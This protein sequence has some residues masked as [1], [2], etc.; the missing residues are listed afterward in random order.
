[1]RLHNKIIIAVTIILLLQFFCIIYFTIKQT[2]EV[3][4]DQLT[5]NANNA[6]YMLAI[7]I[8]DK[9]ERHQIKSINLMVRALYDSGEYSKIKVT[10][11]PDKVI[12][13][14]TMQ[15]IAVES[16]P[17]W[18]SHRLKF[19][20]PSSKAQ[21]MA[22]WTNIG[23]VEV[24]VSP[25]FTYLS[26]W[27]SLKKITISFLII[28]IISVLIIILL[29]KSILKPVR[30]S[31]NQ[32]SNLIL[33][34]YVMQQEIPSTVE[35]RD[36]VI[37]NNNIG[38]R[39]SF[40]F[41]R[42]A[43]VNH[44][45]RESLYLVPQTPITNGKYLEVRLNY[46]LSMHD[47]YILGSL[48]YLP[49]TPLNS[50]D[51]NA[52][53]QEFNIHK[54]SRF[55][56]FIAKYQQGILIVMP[57]DTLSRSQKLFNAIANKYP[58]VLGNKH[59]LF[60][61]INGYWNNETIDDIYR[62]IDS[63]IDSNNYQVSKMKLLHYKLNIETII[64]DAIKSNTIRVF[65]KPTSSTDDINLILFCT[66]CFE[67]NYDNKRLVSNNSFLRIAEKN[68][69]ALL[70]DE[71]M[72]SNIF[73]IIENKQRTNKL[74]YVL[75]EQSLKSDDFIP[76]LINL[77]K[78]KPDLGPYFCLEI[79]ESDA[80]ENMEKASLLANSMNKY[81]VQFSLINF[82][83]SNINLIHLKK[84][85]ITYIK[86]NGTFTSNIK[87]SKENQDYV[88]ELCYICQC[89]EIQ[90][91]AVDIEDTN[92]SELLKSLGINGFSSSGKP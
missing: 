19:K 53:Y 51:A 90:T 78:Q 70:L 71:L 89:F 84:I 65:F 25:N 11:A 60:I 92:D 23:S 72:I 9:I 10:L 75:S 16:I 2:E 82:G 18:F 87:Q 42:M 41:T 43:D 37:A 57:F 55:G 17:P 45:L 91:I 21:I 26:L 35:T 64:N 4:R 5:Q 44:Q 62:F 39:L 77:L 67:I 54:F 22:N 34:E 7:S 24:I 28:Y 1:M 56:L 86:L 40:L 61:E 58:K 14:Y 6:A 33:G 63:K 48:V 85:P 46:L 83:R 36:L 13:D 30:S 3:I 59:P 66:C 80:L 31:I 38:K 12:S 69:T 81:G 49:I 8:Q 73:T 68:N 15:Q 47:E 32:L 79:N 74:S 76:W 50:P 88:R 52:F 20:Q 29:I 27:N